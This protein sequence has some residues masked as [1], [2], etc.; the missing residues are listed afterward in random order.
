[1]NTKSDPNDKP[2]LFEKEVVIA[3][4]KK[5]RP[6]VNPADIE[7]L[8]ASHPGFLLIASGAYAAGYEAAIARDG[9]IPGF[10]ELPFKDAKLC[11]AC[12]TRSMAGN[13]CTT[14]GVSRVPA[15]ERQKVRD[16]ERGITDPDYWRSDG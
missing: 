6:D 16:F 13:T 3:W 9:Y 8:I 14:C 4:F 2:V 7:A 5:R 15:D 11:R 10:D 12:G 1:M